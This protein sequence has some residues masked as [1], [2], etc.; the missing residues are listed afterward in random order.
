ML[1]MLA[2]EAVLAIHLSVILFNL[3]GLIVIPLGA[4][5]NWRFV[6][7]AWLRWLHLAVLAIVAG[8]ALAGRVCF[9]T[10]WQDNLAA[11]GQVTE[12]AIMTWV[13]SLIYWDLPVSFFTPLYVSVFLY[14]AGLS[15]LVPFGRRTRHRLA[16]RT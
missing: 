11:H 7:I 3:A 8:Q 13:N 14:V 15:V 12:P 16:D 10:T 2:A 4:G 6:R 1:D 5:L 9:L